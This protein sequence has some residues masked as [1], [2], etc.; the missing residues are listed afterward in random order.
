MK[1]KILQ[2]FGL[3]HT[4]Q[5]IYSIILLIGLFIIGF[6]QNL[7]AQCSIVASPAGNINASTFTCGTLPLSACNGTLTVGNGSSIT[8]IY[9]DAELNLTCL[10]AIQVIVKNKGSF[11]FSPG[12]NRLLLAEG[13]SIT[14]EPG[15]D[16]IGGSCNASE[17]IYIGTNLLASCN[18]GAGADLSFADLLS[19]AGT[20]SL[21]SNSPVCVG[22]QITLTAT[23][24]P[25]SSGTFTYSFSGPGLAATSFS[26]SPTYSFTATAS[27]AGTYQVKIKNSGITNPMIAENSVSVNTLPATPT[28]TP[29]SSTTF[30]AG[31]SVTLTSSAGT[32]YLWSTGVTT[33]SISATTSGSYTVQVTNAAGCL[34][35]SSL[36]TVVT[37]NPIPTITGTTP[38]SVC[39]TG[40]VTLGAT[41]SA[42]T[43]NWYAASTGG[44]SLGTGTSFTTPS[45]SGTTTY[46][47]DATN[48]GCTTATR[49]AVVATVNPIPTITGTTPSSVCG[50]GTVTLGAT[51]SAGTINWY[52]ASSGGSSLGTGASFTT[53]SISS[54]TTYYVDATN[55]GCTTVTRT[56]VVATVN[57]LPN[58]VTN[59]FSATTICAGGSPQLTFNAE[60]SSFSAPYSIT[61]RNDATLIQYTVAIP[62]SSAYSFTPADNPTS[63]TGYTLVSISNASCTNTTSIVDSG[64][65]L[66]VRPMPTATII[67]TTSVCVGDSSPN[68]T[69][70]NPQSVAI[71]IT[72][73][74]NGGA[75]QTV[76]VA[77]NNSSTVPVSTTAAG[78]FVYNLV[79]VIYQSTPNCS[80]T[81][82]G[83]ATITVNPNPTASAGSALSAI[84]QSS[85]SAAMGG[86]VG[87]GATGGTWS[88]GSGTWTN[89]TNP[90]TATYTA[91]AGESGSITLTLTT[92]GGSCGTVTATKT[93][94][95]NPNPTASAGSA[96]SAICQS[97]TSA[98]MGGSVGGGATGGTWS[99]GSGTWTNA[100]NPSTATYTA[101][102]GESG[103]ITLTLTTS[104]GSCGT[105]TATK[106]I[107]VN[108]NPTAS[109]GSA[110]S[111]ICQS[112]TS[113][114]MGGSVGGVA[115][116]GTWS[117]GSGIWTNATNPSTATYTASAGE[118]GSIT[119][120]LTT[121]GGSCGTTT[122]TK[123]ITVNP[124][125]TASAGSALSAICQSG[126]SAAMGGSVGGGATGGTWSGGSGT[127]TNA[128]NPS[129]AT[130]TASAGESGSI[131]LTLTT[132]GGSCGTV[133]AT[134]T[135][136]V[137]PNPTAS[138]GSAL[139][140]ICQSST[141]AAMGGSVGGGAIGGTWSGGSG[142][143][144][145]ATNPSTATYTASAGES[146][147]ITLTLT[148]SG[149]F[150]GATTATKTITVNPNP[151]ASAGSALS[152]ICQSG[153]SAAMGG[154]VGGGAT[155]GTWSG[156]SGTWIN[157]T[158]PST[159]TYT[160][161]AGES[162]SI[163]LTL[164][165][166][167]GSCGTTTATKN[168]TVNPLPTTPI[169]GTL[170]QP[171]C[172][173]STGS[174]E[175]SG[176]PA[177]GT[178]TI[179]PGGYTGTG[180]TTTISGLAVGTYNFTVYNGTCTSLATANV[181]IDPVITNTW[182][183]S[184]SN[185]TP[186]ILQAIVFNG[187]FSSTAD[188]DACSCQVTTGS[189]VVINSGHTLKITNQ[190]EVLGTG[191]LTFENNASLVQ[192]NDAAINTGNINYKRYTTPVRRYDFTYWSSPVAGQTLKNL[193]P[194]TLGDKYY[195][196]NPSTGWVIYYNGAATMVA[197]NGYLI[198]APETFSITV[199]AIDTNPVFIG[200]PNNGVVSLA[201]TANNSYLLGNPYASAINADAFLDANSTVLEG[202]LYFWTHNSPPSISVAGDAIYNYTSNDYASYNRTGG[203]GTGTAAITGGATPNGKI[204]AGQGFFA[205][206]SVTGGTLVF[207]NSMRITG[208]NSQFFKL[209]TST[210]SAITVAIAEKNR[211]WLNLT[212][213]EG[214]FKQTLIGYLTGATNNYDPGFDG[215]TYDGN[216]YVDFYSVNQGMNLSIQGRALPFVEKDSITLGYKSAIKGEFQISIDH[217]DG[218]L[219]SQTVFLEDKDL[220]ILHDL[221]KEP[222]TFST[223]K[224]VFNTRFML[225]YVEKNTVEQVD[226]TVLVSV[227]KNEISVSSSEDMIS[228]II[229]YDISGA[230]IYQK[231]E[232][233]TN[234]YVIQNLNL[235]P[236]VLIV[237]VILVNGKTTSTKIVY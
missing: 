169:V 61:Y 33:Q 151:T 143:W 190:V 115:T 162:G 127:W 72:Y 123:T 16:L 132:S 220:K 75:N 111:A 35:A 94:T 47:V 102:A 93:I 204:A 215:V 101:S 39:G 11:D 1:R 130:Y 157:A 54:T 191:S 28:I 105:T 183:T 23:P 164:T 22:S 8:N 126:T 112:G 187:N 146:G 168:I 212:N 193:S 51:A 60:A 7:A 133:T 20:G 128:T 119:L 12:N 26:S 110:L 229:I 176:L 232:I 124:N 49:T 40:T 25:T 185:G 150:C 114:A 121:S 78:S 188:L 211:I 210:K 165:T 225:R 178:W 70:A 223:E 58:N 142:I 170:I 214:A 100:T 9:M 138:A 221:R 186:T 64:A 6:N 192:I 196:Y 213:K 226:K 99:G 177:S 136:T 91:S 155:G 181:V 67:G 98:A 104:G 38:S 97:S 182:T 189:S 166:S 56:A 205:P 131:T 145:N 19:Y 117:G 31:G 134:K 4:T 209:S 137:N 103:S 219:M 43:I 203:V 197:G 230:I 163:T 68:I 87:G 161:S 172:V 96:L 171:T 66:I 37:V 206:T 159:A 237:N 89:A 149:G 69:F 231:D 184:W 201:L 81:V 116:G 32:G 218:A 92:S 135:I 109:A 174:V 17:R 82:S 140:A 59:G 84:C 24:P 27:S 46:Y 180:T 65:N 63:N 194:N 74:I 2:N 179:N 113:A 41:A 175:L 173:M 76:N 34:S 83:S 148:T 234:D 80:N 50:T 122:A 106:T 5:R 21:A 217:A 235:A 156:G 90:S 79:S 36:A 85:T 139:S 44:S 55:S 158:N 141:S 154:S 57:A 13:S 10:G 95:V 195:G 216:Q 77:S 73:N 147:S 129:T 88:G 228:K 29:G 167:G 53:P 208:N 120:T 153:T 108:P 152:A 42:G 125:P 86:S 227:N 144:T 202:T 30:C 45:I 118:S 224:G 14:F 207:N 62:S 107:T 48:L 222:Y 18:G 198:R 200:K 15:S 233:D 3:N 71:T 236:Q 52:A 199:A 160:A